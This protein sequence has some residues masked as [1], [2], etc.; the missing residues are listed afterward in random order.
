M[1]YVLRGLLCTGLL[2]V[3]LSA[4]S[5]AQRPFERLQRSWDD[6]RPRGRLLQQ[7][8]GQDKK[9]E[10]KQDER[11]PTLAE[12]RGDR[13]QPVSDIGPAE[14]APQI[15]GVALQE[16]KDGSGLIITQLSS[17][18]AAHAAGLR[19]GDQIIAVGG[20]EVQTTEDLT[21]V[22]G[23][24][25]AG[26]QIE[27]EI[28]RQGKRQTAMV[29][30][31]SSPE[32][33]Q[34]NLQPE[35]DQGVRRHIGDQAS[36]TGAFSRRTAAN[37][38]R[39]YS[40]DQLSG[41]KSV[42]QGPITRQQNSQDAASPRP[43]TWQIAP[44]RANQQRGIQHPRPTNR[45]TSSSSGL[46]IREQTNIMQMQQQ[47]LRQKQQIQALQRPLQQQQPPR[48]IPARPM[49]TDDID[50]PSLGGPGL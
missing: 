17:R 30:F 31:G 16:S 38:S 43:A 50:F 47:L 1:M 24:L 18:G 19:R 48:T 42:L 22:I 45:Q 7:L 49:P 23:I 37:R 40:R 14:Y 32:A 36:S 21:H 27:F 5:Q 10:D 46:P 41:L 25:K 44:P 3:L 33:Q 8:L 20:T 29:Q 39:N 15:L 13:H 34:I 6:L 26:D 4:N 35:P 9:S 12:P 2:L 28:V 11:T